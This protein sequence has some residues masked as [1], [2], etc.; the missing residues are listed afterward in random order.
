MAGE[1]L[2]RRML[3]S[4]A[5]L[6]LLSS[7]LQVQFIL[8][9]VSE[10]AMRAAVEAAEEMARAS[11]RSR[12]LL[13]ARIEAGD[14]AL[15][16]IGVKVTPIQRWVGGWVRG[17]RLGRVLC[18]TLSQWGWLAAVGVVCHVRPAMDADS[19]FNKDDLTVDDARPERWDHTN[20]SGD[21]ARRTSIG[22]IWDYLLAARGEETD[23]FVAAVGMYVSCGRGGLMG[24]AWMHGLGAGGKGEKE[25]GG[26]G[27]DGA[28]HKVM[29]EIEKLEDDIAT[30]TAK[31]EQVGEANRPAL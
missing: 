21:Q 8:Q 4:L 9:V 26:N 3:G 16:K 12:S 13:T 10:E 6:L 14:G 29:A 20:G 15:G 17:V 27:G 11:S 23:G 30:M 5:L 19:F 22:A 2:R 31:K 7:V 1:Q 25:E 28:L 18:W 24:A